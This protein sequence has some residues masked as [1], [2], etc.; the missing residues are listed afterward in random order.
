MLPAFILSMRG[1]R[2]SLASSLDNAATIASTENPATTGVLMFGMSTGLF[3]LREKFLIAIPIT[4]LAFSDAAYSE[5][6]TWVA[7][8]ILHISIVVTIVVPIHSATLTREGI[9]HW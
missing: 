8:D 4:S 1:L 6:S 9:I 3:A 7:P 5:K 2:G